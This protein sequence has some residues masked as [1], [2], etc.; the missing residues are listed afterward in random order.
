MFIRHPKNNLH[1]LF[2]QGRVS[3]WHGFKILLVSPQPAAGVFILAQSPK[4]SS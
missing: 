1:H 2:R 3:H 4:R